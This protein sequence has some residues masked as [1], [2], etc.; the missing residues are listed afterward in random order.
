MTQIAL[1]IDHQ[2]DGI[3]KWF[4]PTI[5]NGLSEASTRLSRLAKAKARRYRLTRTLKAPTSSQAGSTSG[6]PR[7]IEENQISLD[8]MITPI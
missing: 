8:V 2:R 7:E 5:A 4:D 6:Y 3:L 1:M